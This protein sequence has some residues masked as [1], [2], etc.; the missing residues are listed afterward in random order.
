MPRSWGSNI[1]S[2]TRKCAGPPIS[3]RTCRRCS[4][5][6]D[7]PA[8]PRERDRPHRRKTVRKPQGP[9]RT[10]QRWLESAFETFLFN[11]RLIVIL[12]VVGSLTSSV[13]MFIRGVIVI[14]QTARDFL[15]H[16]FDPHGGEELSISL[17]S[18]VD[19]F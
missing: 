19:S 3:H 7:A 4:I 6:F 14:W 2:P 18:S 12:A 16:A 8:R 9:M 1:P 5:F 11:S 13:L 15:H 17:I 10:L